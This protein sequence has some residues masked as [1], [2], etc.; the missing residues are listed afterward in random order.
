MKSNPKNIYIEFA[1]SEG[2]KELKDNRVKKLLSIYEDMVYEIKQSDPRVY[3]E[4]KK[5]Q[6]DKTIGEKLYLYFIQNGKCMYSGEKLEIDNLSNYE[7][8]HII[9]QYY[10]KDDSIDNKTLVIK[11]ENQRKEMKISTI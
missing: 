9:P 8:D 4:L 2:K 1:R 10:I 7:V 5:H 3:K 6:S 11:R